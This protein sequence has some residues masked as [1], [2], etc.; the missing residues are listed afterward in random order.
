MTQ[1]RTWVPCW[2]QISLSRQ[3]WELLTD[4]GPPTVG[5]SDGGWNTQLTVAQTMWWKYVLSVYHRNVVIVSISVLAF[6]GW[7]HLFSSELQ[8]SGLSGRIPTGADS[9]FMWTAMGHF[10]GCSS[11]QHPMGVLS[12]FH[13][14]P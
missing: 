1:D 4:T 11:A 9:S 14:C 5:R 2:T 8:R 12:L 13:Q 7:P 6:N 3:D 10:T